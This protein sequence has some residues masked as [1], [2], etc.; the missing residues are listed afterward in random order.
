MVDFSI[1]FP[2][3]DLEDFEIYRIL[4][5]MFSLVDFSYIRE[6]WEMAEFYFCS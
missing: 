4:F 2:H 5:T 1:M 3:Q 6:D